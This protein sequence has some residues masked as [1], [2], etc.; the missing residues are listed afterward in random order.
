MSLT[1]SIETERLR[2]RPVA[3][4]DLEEFVQL[5]RDPEVIRF[6]EARDRGCTGDLR[7]LKMNP[8]RSDELIGVPVTVFATKPA[9]D[10]G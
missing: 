10:R 1:T 9:D 3:W 7:R 5:H 6:M 8:M 4:D 2:L